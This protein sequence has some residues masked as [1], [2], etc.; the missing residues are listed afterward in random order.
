MSYCRKSNFPVT[1]QLEEHFQKD[2]LNYNIAKLHFEK[3]DYNKVIEVLREVEFKDIFI[4]IDA[5]TLLVK[6][7]FELDEYETLTSQLDSFRQFIVRK[8]ELAYH[9]KY[10]LNTIRFIRQL[11]QLRP[12]ESKLAEKLKKKIESE[13]MLTEKSWLLEKIAGIAV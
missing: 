8:K 5:R 9:S 7:Y 13:A 10:Y 3:R 6:T 4:T 1:K 11:M 12:R 2:Y